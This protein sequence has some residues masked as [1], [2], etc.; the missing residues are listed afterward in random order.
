[1]EKINPKVQLS[2]R[3]IVEAP[4][5]ITKATCPS[6]AKA[7]CFVGDAVQ[8]DEAGNDI[9]NIYRGC[10]SFYSTDDQICSGLTLDVSV[11]TNVTRTRTSICKQACNTADCNT[12]RYPEWQ[13][14]GPDECEQECSPSTNPGSSPTAGPTT[15]STS[16]SVINTIA[17]LLVAG[18]LALV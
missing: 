3:R 11:E 15:E 8:L 17:I 16:S 7:G 6:W 18:I 12:Y 2:I 4:T 9:V 5:E 13:P 14:P 1:L 10:S